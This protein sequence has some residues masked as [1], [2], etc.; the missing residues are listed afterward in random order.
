MRLNRPGSRPL[1]SSYAYEPGERGEGRLGINGLPL[2][3]HSVE[4][5]HIEGVPIPGK[6]YGD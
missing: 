3:G 2:P 5:K 6:F 4:N 1:L